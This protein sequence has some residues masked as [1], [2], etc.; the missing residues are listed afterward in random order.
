MITKSPFVRLSPLA[1]RVFDL[2]LQREIAKDR[3]DGDAIHWMESELRMIRGLDPGS[4][5]LGSEEACKH[6]GFYDDF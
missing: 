4:F 6:I 3:G 1:R 5:I 2:L